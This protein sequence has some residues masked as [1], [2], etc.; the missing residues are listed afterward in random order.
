MDRSPQRKNELPAPVPVEQPGRKW[1]AYRPK[2]MPTGQV[3]CR[4]PFVKNGDKTP[5]ALPQRMPKGKGGARRMSVEG[6][7]PAVISQNGAL[8]AEARNRSDAP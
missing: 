1:P 6:P 2:K 8:L 4:E 7:H 3:H 5:V